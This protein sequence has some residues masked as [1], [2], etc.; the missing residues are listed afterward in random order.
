MVLDSLLL[1]CLRAVLRFVLHHRIFLYTCIV[2]Y[3]F[4]FTIYPF[5][6]L[7]L[8]Y[9]IFYY[10][11]CNKC[12]TIPVSPLF[13][14]VSGVTLGVTLDVTQSGKIPKCNTFGLCAGCYLSPSLWCRFCHNRGVTLFAAICKRQSVTPNVTPSVT[15]PV[16]L[17][18]AFIVCN[19]GRVVGVRFRAF[20]VPG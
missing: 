13:I 3:V 10:Y 8:Y 19:I 18:V 5:L 11:K 7:S 20:I 4:L 9:F 1:L 16:C 2:T 12:N 14:G 6:L 17:N 15:L